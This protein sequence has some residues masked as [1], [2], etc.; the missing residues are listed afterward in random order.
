MPIWV[1]EKIPSTTKP[2][3]LTEEY[4]TSFFMLG[5]T[6]ATSAPYTMPM[7]AS[8]TIHGAQARAAPGNIG[9]QNRTRP[10]VPIFSMTD[11]SITEPAV[12]ASTC[13]SGSQVCS[14]NIGTFT[15]KA[16]KN[17]RKS[18]I[19]CEGLKCSLPLARWAKMSA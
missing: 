19:C 4:A 14:G 2:R 17:A 3:W 13:A 16:K 5:C 18:I 7:M 1:N 11:A 15:A 9:R 6:M 12:G 8:T 10:Y